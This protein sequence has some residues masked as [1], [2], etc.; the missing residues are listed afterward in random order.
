MPPLPLLPRPLPK[1]KGSTLCKRRAKLLEL[2]PLLFSAP[3]DG[4]VPPTELLVGAP[5]EHA[6]SFLFPCDIHP[7]LPMP[8]QVAKGHRQKSQN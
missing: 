8:S 7:H 6:F 5:S 2:T 1:E 4:D 3:P